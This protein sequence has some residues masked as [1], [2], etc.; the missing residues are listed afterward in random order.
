MKEAESPRGLLG[1][2]ETPPPGAEP[3][4]D[5]EAKRISEAIGQPLPGT[6]IVAKPTVALNPIE[7]K[8]LVM[9]RM[10]GAL[11][12]VGVTKEKI[13]KVLYG[14]LEAKKFVPVGGGE[15]Y[16]VDDHGIRLTAVK[17][18]RGLVS[19]EQAPV[20]EETSTEE[21]MALFDD[22]SPE[23]MSKMRKKVTHKRKIVQS[24]PPSIHPIE[25]DE[26]EA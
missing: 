2:P 16:E 15:Y 23:E 7:P 14:A 17:E 19:A 6:E 1:L 11:E 10:S 3:I 4:S 5:K 22:M 9:D 18:I 24:V 8:V 21:I 20:V 25:T 26:A 12:S 13:A